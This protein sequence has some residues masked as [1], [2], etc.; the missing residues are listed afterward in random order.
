MKHLKVQIDGPIGVVTIG[1][2]A[3]R[4]SLSFRGEIESVKSLTKYGMNST[5]S[6]RIRSGSSG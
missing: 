6:P 4:Y 2:P 3:A 1:L 5:S